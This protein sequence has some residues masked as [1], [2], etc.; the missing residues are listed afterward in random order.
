MSLLNVNKEKCIGCG[1]C[2]EVC[3]KNYIGMTAERIPIDVGLTCISCGHCVAVCP[4]SALDHAHASLNGQ[5]FLDK[6][7]VLNAETAEKF[8]RGRR[9]IRV[10]KEETVPKNKI[11]KLLDIARLAPTGNNTQGVQYLVINNKDTLQAITKATVAWMNEAISLGEASAAHFTDLVEHY[12]KTGIDVILRNAPCFILALSEKNFTRG[13]DN[14]HFSLAYAELFA[15]SLGLGTCYAGLVE[16]CARSDYQPLLDVLDIPE[17]LIVTGGII[18]GYPK[19]SYK[20]L[21]DRS[22]LKVTWR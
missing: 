17:N 2:V 19:Y 20:R 5:V 15:L 9:S 1:V 7:P 10:Y 22:P 4:Q 12:H 14:T 3:P 6:T 13:R 18:V 11:L 21:V 16:A 8:L